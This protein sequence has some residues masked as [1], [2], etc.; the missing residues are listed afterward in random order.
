MLGLCKATQRE[1]LQAE[2]GNMPGE[3]DATGDAD[4]AAERRQNGV[5]KC[6]MPWPARPH[7][8]EPRNTTA[9]RN[10]GAAVLDIATVFPVWGLWHKALS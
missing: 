6:G 4:G 1:E 10:Q 5:M 2:E 9:G 3:S 7:R 8:K